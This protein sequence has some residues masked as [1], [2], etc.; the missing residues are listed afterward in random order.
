MFGRKPKRNT[1]YTQTNRDFMK[2]PIWFKLWGLFIA[3]VMVV[4]GI[5]AYNHYQQNLAD[6]MADGYKR[7]QCE[8]MFT[9]SDA[10]TLHT[11][12]Q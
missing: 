12:A 6:C 10:V 1:F 7:Y 8:R 2:T 3:T 5:W 9:V 4:G 11:V